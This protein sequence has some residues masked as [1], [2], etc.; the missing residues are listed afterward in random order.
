MG[1]A[2]PTFAAF[3]AV[4]LKAAARRSSGTG[5][6]MVRQLPR[7]LRACGF[8][9]IVIRPFAITNGQVPTGDFAIHLGPDQFAPL[10][11]EGTLSLADLTLAASC[12][13]RF[14]SDPDAWVLLLGLIIAGRAPADP[15]RT[16][17]RI[18]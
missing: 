16:P 17:G 14:R 6:R 2:R 9:D 3:E 8:T 11:A 5:R 18:T 1:L 13:N 10:V 15:A 12:W 4:H 7:L